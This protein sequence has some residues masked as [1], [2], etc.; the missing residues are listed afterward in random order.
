M[1][2]VG[3]EKSK[4]EEERGRDRDGEL[5]VPITLKPYG[6]GRTTTAMIST[7]NPCVHGK[8]IHRANQILQPELFLNHLNWSWQF[9]L[10]NP[11]ASIHPHIPVCVLQGS[12]FQSCPRPLPSHIHLCENKLL[13]QVDAP[14]SA[15]H[16]AQP[17]ACT[18][19]SPMLLILA[20]SPSQEI[21]PPG[22]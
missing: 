8:Y 18:P 10:G 14:T 2:E 16:T 21:C 6:S 1:K 5:S 22:L 3:K 20:C 7:H 4:G 9:P 17:Y 15:G 19:D 12:S 13:S 11:S